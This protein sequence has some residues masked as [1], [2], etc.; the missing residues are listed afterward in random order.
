MLSGKEIKA[1]G[2]FKKLYG[3]AAAED[4]LIYVGKEENKSG[5]SYK[6]QKIV[7]TSLKTEQS[8]TYYA[9]NI[10]DENTSLYVGQQ[11]I[12]TLKDGKSVFI[13]YNSLESMG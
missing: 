13:S 5:E 12:V 1:P 10:M 7:I 11:G 8:K 4:K 3:F 2:A 6:V 9:N